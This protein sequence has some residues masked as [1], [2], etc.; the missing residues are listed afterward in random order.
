MK[1]DNIVKYIDKFIIGSLLFMMFSSA[2]SI[3]GSSIG[4]GFAFLAWIIKIIIKKI[5]AEDISFV[6]VP[7][8]NAIWLLLA[9]ILISFIGTYDLQHSLEGL[10][11]YLIV[12]L[13]FYTVVNNV[14]DLETVKKMFGFGVLSIILSALYVL[15]YQYL[16]QGISRIDSTFMAL[17]FGALL[18]M[19]SIFVMTYL[20]FAENGLKFKYLSASALILLIVTINHMEPGWVLQVGLL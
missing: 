1:I 18:L 10:E 2:I 16:Y 14:K 17:D 15:F 7:F 6:A 8:S 9:A 19:Y 4:M 11:D 13:L 12:V 3:A 5:K 20:F